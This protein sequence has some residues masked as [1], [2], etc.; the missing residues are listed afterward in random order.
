MQARPESIVAQVKRVAKSQASVELES[1]SFDLCIG[2]MGLVSIVR[3]SQVSS[4][5]SLDFFCMLH[6]E[7]A[8]ACK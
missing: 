5:F 1:V 2:S 7:S 6:N 8:C 4:Y 3:D